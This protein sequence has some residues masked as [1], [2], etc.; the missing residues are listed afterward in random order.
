MLSDL[1]LEIKEAIEK[2]KSLKL[3]LSAAQ[4]GRYESGYDA[5]VDE[6]VQANPPPISPEERPKKRGR[7]KQSKPLNFLHRMRDIKILF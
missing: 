3:A 1:L 4:I 5:L 6:G 7:V 2:A